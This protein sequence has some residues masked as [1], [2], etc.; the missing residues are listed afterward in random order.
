MSAAGDM[1]RRAAEIVDGA[2]QEQHGDRERSFEAVAGLWNAYLAARR[3]DDI[4]RLTG[5]DV[6]QMMAL[7]KI[8]R[9][10][11]GDK[12][13]ADHYVDLAGYAA[14]AGELAGAKP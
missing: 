2:R 12:A 6:C 4:S 8:G 14:L 9:S 13:H 11:Q 1:L 7:L 10:L 3:D 5:F